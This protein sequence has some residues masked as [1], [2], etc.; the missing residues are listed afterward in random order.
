MAEF[1]HVEEVTVFNDG[2]IEIRLGGVRGV[3]GIAV[4]AV[5][6]VDYEFYSFSGDDAKEEAL[7]KYNEL[8]RKYAPKVILKVVEYH[9][10]CPYCDTNHTESVIDTTV[11]CP[12]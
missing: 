4:E 1:K 3:E 6:T 5:N 11:M 7:D 2:D 9:W 10:L 8:A 12:I